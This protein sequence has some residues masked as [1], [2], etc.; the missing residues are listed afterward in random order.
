MRS[1]KLLKTA[2]RS[3]LRNRLRSLLT[4]LGIIIG[5]GAVIVMVAVGQ[6]AQQQIEDRIAALG[7]NL[8]IVF[9]NANRQGG[10]SRG[11]GSSNTLTMDDVDKI[12]QKS[13]LISHVSPIVRVGSQ[14]V[15]GAGNWATSVYGVSPDYLEIRNWKL[16]SGAFFTDKDVQARRKVAV[17]GKTVADQLFPGQVPVGQQI[18]IG[19][20]PFTIAGVLEEKGQSSFGSDQDDVVLAPSL[21]VLYRLSGGQHVQQ[22]Y[23]SA[24]S[25]E[26]IDAAQAELEQVL[27]LGHK[28]GPDADDDFVIR[29]QTEISETASETTRTLTL[30]LGSI[31]GVSLIVGGIGIM[32]IMLVSVT[33]RTREIGL[34][35]AVGARGADVLAQFL[36]EAVV[37]SVLGGAIGVALSLGIAQGLSSLAGLATS[38]N[39]AVVLLSL[40]FSAAVGVFFGYYP[41]RK[42]ASLDPI[43]ALRYE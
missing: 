22:I 16:T 4:M 39:P 17:L 21:T 7:T 9:P 29:S 43:E 5:V 11:A 23:A 1:K 12:R 15:G 34:R 10:V 42:A 32:N 8:L 18:R 28:L 19:K 40:A 30:L 20:T 33:E 6:G 41:A 2:G 38:V 26:V 36:V 3:I 31:A 25:A 13:T 35:I 27:R 14:V 37:M 24:Q